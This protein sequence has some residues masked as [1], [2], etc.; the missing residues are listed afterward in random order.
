MTKDE[1]LERLKGYEW[2][3][4][5]FKQGQH[6]YLLSLPAEKAESGQTEGRVGAESLSE[7]I[8][9]SLTAEPLSKGDIA[10]SVGS[11]C[12]RRCLGSTGKGGE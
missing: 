10:A 6:G 1:L 3:D 4:I 12:G 9:Q 5:E 8:M 2:D 11:K 7:K